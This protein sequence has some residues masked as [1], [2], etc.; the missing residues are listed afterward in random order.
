[1]VDVAALESGCRLHSSNVEDNNNKHGSDNED[2]FLSY[3]I[4]TKLIENLNHIRQ[5]SIMNTHSTQQLQL[6]LKQQQQQ[7]RE[8]Q[9][10]ASYD[11]YLQRLE[12]QCSKDN[13]ELLKILES[14]YKEVQESNRTRRY[15]V[16][17]DSA[18]GSDIT[19]SIEN[20]NSK[21]ENTEE[22][23]DNDDHQH[24]DGVTALRQRLL[25]RRLSNNGDALVPENDSSADKQIENHDNMQQSLIED[26][27]KLVGSLKQGAVAFQTALDEDKKVLGAAEIGIQVASKGLVDISSKLRK[28]DKAK[29]G[30]LFYIGAFLFMIVG[31]IITFII[32]R[33]FPAL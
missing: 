24:D 27:T 11:E 10:L 26:M 9:P 20:D 28:Y 8:R 29:L 25:G 1:M 21:I 22:I 6:Q 7:Q 19:A 15:S 3:I 4:N 31:L 13:Y 33:L 30:Y 32:I 14:K 5:D 23:H 18:N 16:D 2:A 12:F 17:F